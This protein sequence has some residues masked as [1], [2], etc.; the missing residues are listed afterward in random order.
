MAS[1]VFLLQLSDMIW[2]HSMH[3]A[4]RMGWDGMGYLRLGQ[5]ASA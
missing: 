2:K 5:S 3:E 4:L 1:H